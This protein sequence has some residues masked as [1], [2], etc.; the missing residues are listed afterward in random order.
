MKKVMKFIFG[1][2]IA[3][4]E[5]IAAL[6]I[7]FGAGIAVMVR[8]NCG[9]AMTEKINEVVDYTE[10]VVEEK[11]DDPDYGNLSSEETNEEATEI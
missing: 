5:A 11:L 8:K 3:V 2:I 7:G 9:E 6:G 1:A 4:F 10:N